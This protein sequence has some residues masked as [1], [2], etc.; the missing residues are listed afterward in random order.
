MDLKPRSVA[1]LSLLALLPVGVF[2]VASGHMTVV[3]SVFAVA[4]VGL[5]AGSLFLLFGE[6][7]ADVGNG[8]SH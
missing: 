7:P 8:T 1:A 2:I 6:A 5:I 3:T 4:C